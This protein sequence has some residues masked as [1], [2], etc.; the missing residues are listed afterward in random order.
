M[1]LKL[2]ISN[3]LTRLEYNT[4][5]NVLDEI[6]LDLI[7]YKYI[8]YRYSIKSKHKEAMEIFG[9]NPYLLPEHDL[10][11]ELKK[12]IGTIGENTK[13]YIKA[14]KKRKFLEISLTVNSVSITFV[15][16][17]TD[18]RMRYCRS[19]NINFGKDRAKKKRV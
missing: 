5:F 9:F 16:V 10:Y 12:A 15:Y 3:E 4:F 2:S 19:K 1:E 11:E 7:G 8:G 13:C 18:N 17:Q 14:Q 6:I